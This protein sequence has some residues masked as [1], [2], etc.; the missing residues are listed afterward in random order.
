MSPSSRT[1][2]PLGL[3]LVLA[4]GCAHRVPA[5]GDTVVVRP[6]P[7]Q[8][9]TVTAAEIERTPE[10]SVEHALQGRIS[11]VR[12]TQM[13]DGGISVRIR[14]TTSI[15][16]SSEPLFVL[17]GVAIEP[18]PGGSLVGINMRD[19]ASIEVLKDAASTAMYGLRGA[20]GVIV[21]KTKRP[22]SSQ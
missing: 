14:G 8:S 5:G 18:G 20:N 21:I 1:L 11:G 15:N 4:A 3:L 19:I 16:A 10:Q 22:G 17:D 2:L 7:S 12:V 6:D 9:T 13:P